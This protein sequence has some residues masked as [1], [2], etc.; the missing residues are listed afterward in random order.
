[1]RSD[2]KRRS[3]L[4]KPVNK[5]TPIISSLWILFALSMVDVL[6]RGIGGHK[7]KTAIDSRIPRM[8]IK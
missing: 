4:N 6:G 2:S 3:G 7:K 5:L 8:A 1:M